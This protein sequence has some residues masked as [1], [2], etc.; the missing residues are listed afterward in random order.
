MPIFVASIPHN[1]Y[2]VFIITVEQVVVTILLDQFGDTF[3]I[4]VTLTEDDG[5]ILAENDYKLL[6]QDQEKA[7]QA[8]KEFYSVHRGRTLK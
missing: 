3:T 2:M 1:Q 8:I 4:T 6:V 7:R 5:N